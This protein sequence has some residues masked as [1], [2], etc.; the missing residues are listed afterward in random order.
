MLSS[1]T[2]EPWPIDAW[3]LV[4]R[5]RSMMIPWRR[6][7]T[8]SLMTMW[9]RDMRINWRL[10]KPL[11]RR[12]SSG[13]YLTQLS[14]IRI[15]PER[16]GSSWILKANITAC[17]EWWACRRTRPI[18]QPESCINYFGF[19]K[20]KWLSQ[21]IERPYSIS[22]ESS[23]RTNLPWNS[24]GVIWS[25]IVPPIFGTASSPLQDKLFAQ[26]TAE[27]NRDGPLFS[28]STIE[29]VKGNTCMDDLLK[30]VVMRLPSSSSSEK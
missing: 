8:R 26:E 18:E 5:P 28:L 25:C 1:L 3:D 16:W 23:R 9:Q 4:R 15:S 30:S 12:R 2:T 7:I 14:W 29:A 6:R 21:P 24:F 20:N 22:A 11:F 27:D 10:K 19:E 17:S 13:S